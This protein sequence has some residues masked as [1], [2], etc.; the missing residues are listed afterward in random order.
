MNRI[1]GGLGLVALMMATSSSEAGNM[2]SWSAH[3][4]DV[5][6]TLPPGLFDSRPLPTKGARWHC[7]ADKVLRQDAGGNTFSTL[8]VRCDDGETT[9]SAAASCAIGAHDRNQLSFELLEKSSL[10]NTIRA[11]CS[12]GF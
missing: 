5:A 12:D 1:S 6:V 4:G 2:V 3:V 10:K 8:T 11:E 9:V 7:V